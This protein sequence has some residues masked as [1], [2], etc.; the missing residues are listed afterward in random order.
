MEKAS[1]N[2][3]VRSMTMFFINESIDEKYF[4]QRRIK[5]E[6][7]KSQLSCIGT[8]E[9][10][11][12]YITNYDDSLENLLVLLGVSTELFKRVVSL[13]RIERGMIFQTEWSIDA[14]RR[15]MLSDELMMKR[16]CDLF[17]KGV[18]D[19]SL[20]SKISRYRLSSFTINDKV[21]RRIKN[22]DFLD[23][24][25][26]K[27]FDTAYNSEVSQINIKMIDAKLKEICKGNHL[28]LRTNCSV[29]SVGNS[30]QNN[31][32]NYVIYKQFHPQPSYYIKYSF[33]VTTSRGQTDF[34]RSVQNLRTYIKNYNP[35]A[36][37]IVIIDGAGWVGRQSDLHDTWDY[38]D[39]CFNL[40]TID[41]LHYVIE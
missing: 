41:N 31:Q 4:E 27:D 16:I 26:S 15:Y 23:F 2:D 8:R 29:N 22:M 39:Y 28:E 20:S 10:L 3:F 24:L 5:L 40:N 17:L 18:E 36:K 21:L 14:T 34:K 12:R 25:I 30:T 37:Q 35:G 1:Y 6:L 19:S 9:G 13:F 33:N 32:V 11:I 38:C 7:L